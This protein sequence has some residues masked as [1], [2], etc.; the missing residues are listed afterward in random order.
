MFAF[1]HA[2]FKFL[3]FHFQVSFDFAFAQVL[4]MLGTKVESAVHAQVILGRPVCRQAFC[5]LLGIGHGRFQKLK[6]AVS[7]GT[8][9][10]DGRFVRKVASSKP[11]ANRV[12]VTEFLEELYQTLSEPMPEASEVTTVMKL[13]FRRRKGKRPRIASRQNKM[14]KDEKKKHQM[15]FL[16]PGSFTD[17]LHMLQARHPDKRISLKLFSSEPC[18]G[19]THGFPLSQL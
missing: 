9:L 19:I 6:A 17:F 8:P 13:G 5:R 11:H 14:T 4:K 3:N 1:C 15:R 10:V 2:F 7:K 12:L 16:P 18:W